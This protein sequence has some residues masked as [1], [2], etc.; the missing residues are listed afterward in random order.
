M[1]TTTRKTKPA[2]KKRPAAKAP[3]VKPVVVKLKGA[4]E[5]TNTWQFEFVGTAKEPFVKGVYIHKDVL[6]L[7]PDGPVSIALKPYVQT[8]KK[9]P[10]P[11]S[12]IR[13]SGDAETMRDLYVNRA[14]AEKKG[15]SNESTVNV[16]VSVVNDDTISLAISP[17]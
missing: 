10:M 6:A 12:A 15:F 3:A 2:A 13:Y 9:K 8:G 16:V 1:A 17:A 4:D 14:Q 7:L 11:V 5:T